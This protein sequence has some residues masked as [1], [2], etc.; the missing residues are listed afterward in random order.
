LAIANF[1][2]LYDPEKPANAVFIA[3]KNS[4]VG[5]LNRMIR[6]QLYDNSDLILLN[7]EQVVLGKT[8]YKQTYLPSAESGK[9]ISFNPDS[10]ETIA[11]IKFAEAT[12]QFTAVTGETIEFK[13]K[14]DLDYLLSDCNTDTPE[15]YKMLWAERKRMNPFFRESNNPLDDP[16]LS[17]LKI[18]YGYAITAHKAQ[19]G[20]WE[21]VFLYPEFP[22]NENRLK[23]IYTAVTRAKCD[24][25]S[26]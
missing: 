18:K 13:S 19:G 10:L 23:W 2:K 24:L 26:F 21:N 20:E 6:N 8:T 1:C 17:S 5:K 22:S 16:Y 25:Y 12:F 3:Y 11:E 4:T 9:V 14:F 15:R 7:S